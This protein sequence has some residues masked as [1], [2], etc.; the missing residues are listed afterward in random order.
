MLR[1]NALWKFTIVF[2]ALIFEGD[3]SDRVLAADNR[4]KRNTECFQ[5]TCRVFETAR[6]K[7]GGSS[8]VGD[9]DPITLGMASTDPLAFAALGFTLPMPGTEPTSWPLL[10]P[11]ANTS[12]APLLARVLGYLLHVTCFLTKS[13]NA[14]EKGASE[15]SVSRDSAWAVLSHQVHCTSMLLSIITV[16]A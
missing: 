14:L 3:V 11:K 10:M 7:P 8:A 1:K 4:R 16:T 12:T 13:K 15:P 9:N 6:V 5:V 2:G